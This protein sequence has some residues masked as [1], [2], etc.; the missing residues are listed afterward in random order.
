MQ[1]SINAHAGD[2]TALRTPITST[3]TDDAS[4]GV[5]IYIEGLIGSRFY[6]RILTL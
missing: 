1:P 5:D 2:G 4:P 6:D 3:T